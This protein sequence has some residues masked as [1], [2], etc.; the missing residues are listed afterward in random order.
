MRRLVYKCLRV[1]VCWDGSLR[2]RGEAVPRYPKL[3]GSMCEEQGKTVGPV[4]SSVT[5]GSGREARAGVR[6][7]S[8]VE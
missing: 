2:K 3:L 5:F 7:Q 4:G 6:V 8:K 1:C